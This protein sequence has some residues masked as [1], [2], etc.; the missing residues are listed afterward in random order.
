MRNDHALAVIA[1]G[2]GIVFKNGISDDLP[3]VADHLGTPEQCADTQN[4]LIDVD[5]LDH[6][7]IGTGT[8]AALHIIE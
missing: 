2:H 5:G 6:I 3:A 4:H 8:E 7:V 1:H